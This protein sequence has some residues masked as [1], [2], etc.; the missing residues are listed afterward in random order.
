M[1][2]FINGPA[3]PG[4]ELF[5]SDQQVSATGPITRGAYPAQ[6]R[7]FLGEVSIH[8]SRTGC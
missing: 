6:L 1:F 3:M 7:G 2:K 5:M 4:W 8:N